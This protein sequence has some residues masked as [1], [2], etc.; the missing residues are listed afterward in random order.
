MIPMIDIGL[1]FSGIRVAKA[2]A[3]FSGILDSIGAKVDRLVQSDLNAGL[4]ALEQA[5][6]A[7]SEQVSLLREARNC[8]NKAVSLEM[9]YRQVVALLGLSLCHHWLDDKLNCKKALEEILEINPVT[10]LQLA[11]S[12]GIDHS[13]GYLDYLSPIGLLSHNWLHPYRLIFSSHARKKYYRNLVMDAVDRNEEAMA[14]RQI[15]ESV[16]RHVG[17]QISWL[18]ALG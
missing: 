5:A 10:K 17:K 12:A 8:F 3:E 2:V 11:A 6:H 13:K 9:G 15:Q 14:I 18:K 4:R 1:I 16:S 7:T